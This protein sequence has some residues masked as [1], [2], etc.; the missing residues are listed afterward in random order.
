MIVS[1][2]VYNSIPKIWLFVG[3]LFLLLALAT[4]PDFRY[5]YAHLSLSAI[6]IVRAFQ[7]YQRRRK[8]SRRNQIMV[9]VETQRIER[10]TP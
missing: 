3:I 4:G 8:F 10:D 2:R 5:F 7:I 9:L 6:C 1:D